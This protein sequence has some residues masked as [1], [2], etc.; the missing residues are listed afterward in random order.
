M[1]KRSIILQFT[2]LGIMIL[3]GLIWYMQTPSLSDSEV[4][5]IVEPQLEKVYN[6][7]VTVTDVHYRPTEGGNFYEVTLKMEGVDQTFTISRMAGEL[8][9]LPPYTIIDQIWDQQFEREAKD[10][11]TKH[12][13][14]IKNI[15]ANVIVPKKLNIPLEKLPPI[16]DLR[17][18]YGD[19]F[20]SNDIQVALEDKFPKDMAGKLGEHQ[21]VFALLQD[22]QK[23][24]LVN[25]WLRI[26]YWDAEQ[27][28]LINSD[29]E[30]ATYPY[31]KPED[32]ETA[33]QK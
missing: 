31:Q 21:R 4:K 13:F 15:T 25:V 22:L 5:E 17:N 7:N 11:F 29:K 16:Q 2:I 27:I 19:R 14:H 20:E 8:R 32:L 1:K 3:G 9:N 30:K 28:Y 23:K 6:R 24:N 33:L 10:I 26:R 18:T 12:G